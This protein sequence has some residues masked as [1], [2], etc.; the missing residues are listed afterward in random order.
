MTNFVDKKEQ[1]NK[2]LP[3]GYRDFLKEIKERV[4]KAQ[5]KASL[6][7]NQELIHLYWEIGKEIVN[8]QEKQKWGSS[9]ID[10]LA[11]DLRSS[12]PEIKG[13]SR[14]NIFRMRAFYLA[15]QKVAQPARQLR[16]DAPP[17]VFASIPWWHNITIL[18][19][20]DSTEERIWYAKKTIENGWSRTVL[21]WQIDSHLYHRQGG[22]ITNF[23]KALPPPQSDLARKTLKDPYLLDFLTLRE[24]YLERELEQGLMDHLQKFLIELG[25]GFAFVGRQY[26][27]EVGTKDY[28]IDMLLYHLKLRCYC[29]VELKATEFKP[30]DVGQ[31]NF[32]LSAVDDLLRH[33]D[34][35]PTIG[36]LLC[37]S[38]DSVDVE[39]AL[40]GMTSP[41]GITGFET[42]IVDS[43][44]KELQSSLPSVEEI[45]AELETFEKEKEEHEKKSSN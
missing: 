23:D 10:R 43:L 41:I 6:A 37:K 35:Q 20:V 33:P 4:Q 19:K 12:F 44:P 40:R 36:M 16:I 5:V 13:F 28:F 9:V 32:Y 3:E 45:E 22:A 17:E 8:R 1:S 7:V 26:N 21:T 30:A 15:C 34:D 24:G 18:E 31:L 39:Y 38:K 25:A 29:V 11:K 27:L 14:S 42:Q 2:V